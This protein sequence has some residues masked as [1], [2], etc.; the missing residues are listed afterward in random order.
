MSVIR[1]QLRIKWLG[2]HDQTA[3][4][5]RLEAKVNPMDDIESKKHR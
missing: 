5:T 1:V 3:D 2:N 4:I